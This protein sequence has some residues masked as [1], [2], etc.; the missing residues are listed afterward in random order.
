MGKGVMV[1]ICEVGLC[2]GA[3]EVNS[4]DSDEETMS[5]LGGC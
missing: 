2:C 1:S 4:D 3:E 5:E